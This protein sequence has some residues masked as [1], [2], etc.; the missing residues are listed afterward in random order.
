MKA[1]IPTGGRGTR[2]Q[3]LTFST[4]KHFIPIANKPLIFY[5]LEAIAETGIKDVLITY[6]PGWLEPVKKILGSGSKWGLKFKYV[7]QDKPRGLAHVIRVCEEA[8]AGEDFLFHLGDNIFTEGIRI[9]YS[10][11]NCNVLRLVRI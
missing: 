7:L 9:L 3:P 5:P 10:H 2:M 4:N 11:L 8:L 1:I 6:N